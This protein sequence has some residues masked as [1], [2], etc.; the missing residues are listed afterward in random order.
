MTVLSLVVV[1]YRSAALAREAIAGFRRE[2]EA[3]GE[4][5]EVVVVENSEEAEAFRGVADLTVEPGRNLGFAGGINAGIAAARGDLLFL[6]NPDLVFRPGS[7][8]SLAA[9]VRGGRAPVAAGPAFFL[10]DAM[11]I[12]APPA[13]EPHPFDLVRRRI[14][15]NPAT[16]ERPFRRRLRRAFAEAA[17]T[18]RGEVR[19]AP[20]LS[21][22][23]VATTRET[24]ERVGPFDG[25]YPLYYE[26]NDWQRRLRAAGGTL[27]TAGSSRVVHRFGRSTRQ[28]PRS[29][30]WFAESER[31]YFARHFGERGSRGLDALAA[32]PPWTKPAPSPLAAGALAW[33]A[34]GAVGIA[35]STLPWFSP[36]AWAPL[37]EGTWA[38]TPPAGFVEGLGGPCYARAV[39]PE[40]AELLSEATLGV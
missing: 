39:D 38:W 3:A 31:R 8:A 21:G 15:L 16:A 30:G 19:S 23:L 12:H 1:N 40:T 18:A 6:A 9:A 36:F 37:T 32:M 14:S 27:L 17:A 4:R 10:D 5:A 13:E 29:A 22:A 28:E 20:A 33:T 24:L 2:A 25:G 26:E 34:R 7:V 35:I 11:T